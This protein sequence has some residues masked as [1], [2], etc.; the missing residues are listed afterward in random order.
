MG[1]FKEDIAKIKAF[2]FDCDGVMTDGTVRMTDKGELMREFNAKDGFAVGQALAAG[3]PVAIV[4]GG[5]GSAMELRF[6]VLGVT[7]IYLGTPD[8][9]EAVDDFRYKYGLER[10]DILFMGDDLPDIEV[11][12]NVGLSVAPKD[13]ALEVKAIARHVSEYGGG[14]GCVRDV[15]EQ[16]M[17]ARGD[18]NRK[19]ENKQ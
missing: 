10:E 9:L 12:Q 18:W 11:M 17:K 2:A 1:N 13:A 4:S 15:I 6:K 16:V 5:R 7:D 19:K 14:K 8:K 3:Y